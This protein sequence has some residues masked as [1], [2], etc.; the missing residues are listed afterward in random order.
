MTLLKIDNLDIRKVTEDILLIH[1]ITP[2]FF[3]SCCDGFLVL[4]K[5][6]RNINTIA[7]DLNIEPKYVNS[8]NDIYGPISNYVCSHGHL[9]H[10]CHVHAWEELRASIYA[11]YPEA[12]YLL[13]LHN[14]YKGFGFDEELDFDTVKQFGKS[15]GFQKCKQVNSFNPG[16]S[17]KFENFKID[18]IS[19]SGHSKGHIG[20]F[21]PKERVFH[22]SCLGFDKPKPEIEGFGPWYGFKQCS[23]SHYLEDINK[24][25]EIFLNKAQILT[26]SHSYIVRNPDLS[27]FEYMRKKIQNNQEKVDK[28]LRTMNLFDKSENEAVNELLM[29]DLFFP[30][31]KLKGVV[32]D[33][34]RFWESWIIR[35]HIQ[36]NQY[37]KK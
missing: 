24:A 12:N 7:L 15:N 21:L 22:I 1:Q 32:L 25:E 5:T 4:P 6:G 28:A 2:P 26:S 10:T 17:L 30:K 29:V 27:P 31:K 19:F 37:F 36:Q 9:D 18:T 33:I 3:F 16:E 20:F 11:P 8:L 14:F 23:I 35:K 13:D 34:Y